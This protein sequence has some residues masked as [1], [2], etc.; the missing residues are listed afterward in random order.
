MLYPNP[1]LSLP[2]RCKLLLTMPEKN[3]MNQD[4]YLLWTRNDKN[5]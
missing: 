2:R 4:A 5:E 3:A 1:E